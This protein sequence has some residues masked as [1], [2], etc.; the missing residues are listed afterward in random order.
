[1]AA[2]IDAGTLLVGTQVTE[3]R[4]RAH[5]PMRTEVAGRSSS[6]TYG[7]RCLRRAR[8][9]RAQRPRS[10]SKQRRR[11]PRSPFP[12]PCCPCAPQRPARAHSCPQL[13]LHPCRPHQMAQLRTEAPQASSRAGGPSYAT[14]I[15]SSLGGSASC[16]RIDALSDSQRVNRVRARQL[17]F[18]L[19]RQT[20]RSEQAAS[21]CRRTSTRCE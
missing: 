5:N 3:T 1:M 7:V 8:D 6:N 16:H 2:S 18:A 14:H 19:R 21:L 4:R 9:A 12:K 17:T 20:C 13:A 10:R 15:A 11:A